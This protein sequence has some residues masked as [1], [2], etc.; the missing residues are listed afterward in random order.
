MFFF[1]KQQQNS[2]SDSRYMAPLVHK[3]FPAKYWPSM[4]LRNPSRH[5]AP[6]GTCPLNLFWP[7]KSR[8][9][10]R[11]ILLESCLPE[12]TFLI[13]LCTRATAFVKKKKKLSGIK[14]YLVGRNTY[15][16]CARLPNLCVI[17]G[18][19][20]VKH[21][22]P[23][24]YY[25]G[26]TWLRKIKATRSREPPAKSPPNGSRNTCKRECT[27]SNVWASVHA[28]ET[29]CYPVFSTPVLLPFHWLFV[30]EF[31]LQD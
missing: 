26:L 28:W 22:F 2:L 30:P 9:K 13:S 14:P 24:R 7:Q 10:H 21:K 4:V 20:C 17:V 12:C 31:R 25:T 8:Q 11:S 23:Q 27:I 3:L 18:S 19:V 1:P 6:L 15:K 29:F 16:Y 5:I